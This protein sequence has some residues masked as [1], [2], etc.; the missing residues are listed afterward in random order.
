MSDRTAWMNVVAKAWQDEEFKHK[1]LSNPKKVLEEAGV[2]VPGG[3]EI[4]IHEQSTNK[5]NLILPGKPSS[6]SN[7][8]IDDLIAGCG[9]ECK[10]ID[11]SEATASTATNM[12]CDC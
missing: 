4:A 9:G 8:Y 3:A 12:N 10:Y 11:T 1:L 2:E 7:T 5:F 6:I